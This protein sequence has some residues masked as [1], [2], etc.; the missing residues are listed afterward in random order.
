[1]DKLMLTF[2]VWQIAA[3]DKIK[4]RREAGQG[5]LEYIGMIAVAAIIIAAVAGAVNDADFKSWANDIIKS[6]KD[7]VSG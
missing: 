1:M 5:T 3:A 4:A 6:V 2:F 7:A